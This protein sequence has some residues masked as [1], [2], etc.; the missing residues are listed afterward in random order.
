[1]AEPKHLN[2]IEPQ[3]LVQSREGIPSDYHC[4]CEYCQNFMGEIYNNDNDKYY[5][6]RIRKGYYVDKAGDHL[7]VGHVIGYKWV[8]QNLCQ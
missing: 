5:S 4:D 3:H 6:N 1:M 8:V 7:D 2:S